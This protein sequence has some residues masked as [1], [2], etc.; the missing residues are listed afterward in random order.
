MKGLGKSVL[1]MAPNASDSIF[2]DFL[3]ITPAKDFN[4][5]SCPETAPKSDTS[6]A[7]LYTYVSLILVG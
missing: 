1:T 2:L 6:E 4:P 7:A 5:D 3:A